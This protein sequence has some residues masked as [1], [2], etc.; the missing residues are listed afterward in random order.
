MPFE[1]ILDELPDL[2]EAVRRSAWLGGI[3]L[4]ELQAD[5]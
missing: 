2:G 5:A 4:I 3:M 1:L